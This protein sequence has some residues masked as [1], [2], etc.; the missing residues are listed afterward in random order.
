MDEQ[1]T[2]PSQRV[3]SLSEL[4]IV[5][6]EQKRAQI[7][8]E[9]IVVFNIFEFLRLSVSVVVMYELLPNRCNGFLLVVAS[10]HFFHK[11]KFLIVRF[12]LRLGIVEHRHKLIIDW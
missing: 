11:V 12:Q 5:F 6:L 2:E 9:L 10:L 1:F 7:L 8:I 3:L 4:D